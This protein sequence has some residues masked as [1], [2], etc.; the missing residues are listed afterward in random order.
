VTHVSSGPTHHQPDAF[1]SSS[2]THSFPFYSPLALIPPL[3]YPVCHQL[4]SLAALPRAHPRFREA[5]ISC[6]CLLAHQHRCCAIH[7][8]RPMPLLVRPPC[9]MPSLSADPDRCR[10]E[11]TTPNLSSRLIL[12]GLR[13][14]TPAS[15]S[16]RTI[17]QCWSWV[18]HGSNVTC[19]CYNQ[20][21]SICS[22]ECCKRFSAT[23]H[24]LPAKA[25]TAAIVDRPCC[26]W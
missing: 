21:C 25:T 26:K 23:R 18:L 9:H 4:H 12:Q 11:C 15:N 8:P 24:L 17:Y 6:R 16:D 3:P 13:K 10:C 5:S 20:G 7:P 2:S 19:G 22:R 14:G 1:L